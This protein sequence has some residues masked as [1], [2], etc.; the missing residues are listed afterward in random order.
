MSLS[1]IPENAPIVIGSF[2]TQKATGVTFQVL[3]NCAKA[4]PKHHTAR[5]VQNNR[6]LFR[7]PTNEE[8]ANV[9]RNQAAPQTKSL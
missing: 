2:L 6:G 8:L 5:F 1:E 4:T 3:C 9:T 7:Y